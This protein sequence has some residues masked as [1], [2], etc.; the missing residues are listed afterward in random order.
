MALTIDG[1]DEPIALLLLSG[2]VGGRRI[3]IENRAGTIIHKGPTEQGYT[4]E[5]RLYAANVGAAPA[6][7]YLH[8]GRRERVL[9]IPGRTSDNGQFHGDLV[10]IREDL[11]AG[12]RLV[13]RVDFKTVYVWGKAIRKQSPPPSPF[14][15]F[16]ARVSLAWL[17]LRERVGL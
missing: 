11:A 15:R 16:V 8:D 9:I 5:V 2:S 12:A 6:R 14:A 1:P 10:P 4:D 17:D 3:Q 13:G 7:L